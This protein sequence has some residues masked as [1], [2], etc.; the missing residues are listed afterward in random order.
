MK[1]PATRSLLAS[2]TDS[3]VQRALEFLLSKRDLLRRF[4]DVEDLI[5]HAD[6]APDSYKGIE[7]NFVTVRQ[8]VAKQLWGRGIYIGITVIDSLIFQ[9]VVHSGRDDPLRDMLEK[10]RDLGPHRPGLVLFPLHSLGVIAGGLYQ[11]AHGG[12]AMFQVPDFGLVLTP[13]TNRFE[14]T[15]QFLDQGADLLGIRQR[16]P[17]DLVEHW[18]RS[19]P[20]EWL[21]KNPLM[22]ARMSTFPGSY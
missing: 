7:P 22:L 13:Q 3:K 2:L 4:V 21:E 5:F 10:L 6:D 12:Q 20:T 9:S 19:R 11:W 16:P 17:H 1:L 15:L 8:A 18:R 14:R